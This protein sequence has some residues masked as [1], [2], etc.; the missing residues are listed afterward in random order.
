[1]FTNGDEN[2]IF[3]FNMAGKDRFTGQ[4]AWYGDSLG[5]TWNATRTSSQPPAALRNFTRGGGTTTAAE[6]DAETY[7]GIY[8]SQFAN[9]V[10][11]LSRD[12]F[13]IGDYG[14]RGIFAGMWDGDSFVGKFTNGERTGWFDFA[15][16]PGSGSFKSGDWGWVGQGRSGSWWLSRK[17]KVT[18]RIDNVTDD[19]NCP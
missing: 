4:W 7:D 17:T 19:V 9:E 12:M 1:V 14:N 10:R 18:P 2:G 16:D 8:G 15:F 3:R 13:L 5:G 6:T 11:L